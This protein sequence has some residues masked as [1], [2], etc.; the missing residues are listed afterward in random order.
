MNSPSLLQRLTPLLWGGLAAIL[1]ALL[2]VA[3]QPITATFF[4]PVVI[5]LLASLAAIVCISMLLALRYRA[6][7]DRWYA[8]VALVGACVIGGMGM[9]YGGRSGVPSIQLFGSL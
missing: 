7:F 9:Q 5:A 3:G 4:I 8:W 1:A 6:L 2:A